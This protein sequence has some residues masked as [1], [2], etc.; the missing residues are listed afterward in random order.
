M[1]SISTPDR[2]E[3]SP[4]RNMRK[5]CGFCRLRKIRCSG[6]SI[7][8][9]CQERNLDC[10]YGRE[11]AK[12]RPKLSASK[13]T[14]TRGIPSKASKGK[15]NN[16][17]REH[18]APLSISSQEAAPQG[19]I[20]P[21]NL[22]I[23]SWDYL[24]LGPSDSQQPPLSVADELTHI[25]RRLFHGQP[26]ISQP[27]N[28]IDAFGRKTS[29]CRTSLPNDFSTRQPVSY[30]QPMAVMM[31][32]M[33]ELVATRFGNLACCPS[34]N[35]QGESS[36]SKM[37]RDCLDH[38]NTVNM[39]EEQRPSNP[40]AKYS[41]YQ[42]LQKI[43]IWF[44]HHPLAFLLSKTLLIQNFRNGTHSETLLAVVL[45]DVASAQS[46]P[47]A[48]SHGRI[49]FDWANSNLQNVSSRDLD[50]SLIQA[51]IL[52]GW[53]EMCAIRV[54]RSVTFLLHAVTVIPTLRKP[55]LC[56]NRINGLDIGEVEIELTRNARWI[57][58]SLV[59]WIF[60]QCDAPMLDLLPS[61]QESIAFPPV[62]ETSS[63][64][65]ALD[66]A[67][68]NTSTLPHQA[69]T[70]RDLWPIS[71]VASTTAHIYAL[72]PRHKPTT[73]ALTPLGTP[74][75]E[76]QTLRRLQ[77]LN[78]TPRAAPQDFSLLCHKVR[79][80]LVGAVDFLETREDQA[81]HLVLSAYH[82]L[83]IHFLF[84][85]SEFMTGG[86]DVRITDGLI[87]DFC[88]SIEALLRVSPVRE[89]SRG[90]GGRMRLYGDDHNVSAEVFMIGL[91]ACSRVFA[92]LQSSTRLSHE[93]ASTSGQEELM[94]LASGLRALLRRG[95]ELADLAS[96]L[97]ALARC[98]VLRSTKRSKAVKRQLKEV[99][100][101]FEC[102]DT[103]PAPSPSRRS[104]HGRSPSSTTA[105]RD[106]PP[107]L[108]HSSS[109][110]SSSTDN[111]TNVFPTEPFVVNST[112]LD[113]N[114]STLGG[115]FEAFPFSADMN[116]K[117][118]DDV[119]PPMFG[120]FSFSNA[121]V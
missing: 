18:S 5:S 11:G 67:S 68:D 66:V 37:F 105:T 93:D 74:S 23:P 45:G 115:Y 90:E 24:F 54:R 39:F 15:S 72:Y 64:I 13:T 48:R 98:E 102:S 73:A 55:D 6:Q 86:R 104:S 14:S 46:S 101:G 117:V 40:L 97:Q 27:S 12:G 31:E 70:I 94:M 53:Y 62:N 58:F 92:H 32:D 65:Y 83:I 10:V 69:K 112:F 100:R 89:S 81:S 106:N 17:I 76:S 29:E 44:S 71:H 119:Y 2:S 52:L 51:L 103:P 63:T 85:S 34:G 59:L 80:V 1:S 30:E 8:S 4:V 82:A 121:E 88:A 118:L 111:S 20:A 25:F 57:T 50:L 75:W 21:T 99:V 28:A 9:A 96:R 113:T 38:D 16:R 107:S 33:V 41:N 110:D 60:M 78:E 19:Y 42:T 7:C 91:D 114:D 109:N 95:D 116:E 36:S 120:D 108:I 87:E 61:S 26:V 35:S 49:L 22:P 56:L 3:Q 47:E 84:P 43:D 77:N 79:H